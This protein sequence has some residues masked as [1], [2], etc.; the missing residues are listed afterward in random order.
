MYIET[1][2]FLSMT[3]IHMLGMYCVYCIREFKKTKLKYCAFKT[4][5]VRGFQIISL[6]FIV[7]TLS[8]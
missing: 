4:L 7:N 6:H 8:I 2:H 3:V 1:L 5:I